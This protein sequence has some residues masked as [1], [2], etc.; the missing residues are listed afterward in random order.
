MTLNSIYKRK[1]NMIIKPFAKKMME[2]ALKELLLS[3]LSMSHG[4][5]TERLDTTVGI[6]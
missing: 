5:C 2:G 4:W 6:Y 1:K 3:L